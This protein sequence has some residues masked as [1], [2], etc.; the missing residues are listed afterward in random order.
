MN[1]QYIANKLLSGKFLMTCIC[2]YV[3]AYCAINNIID[4]KDTMT[5]ITVVVYAYFS[6]DSK[7]NN[8]VK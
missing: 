5:I 2:S 6:K 7:T 4:P 3:F 8:E 1:Y